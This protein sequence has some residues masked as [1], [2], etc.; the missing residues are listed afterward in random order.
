MNTK[1]TTLIVISVIVILASTLIAA[2][3]SGSI[4][5]RSVSEPK[6][7]LHNPVLGGSNSLMTNGPSTRANTGSSQSPVPDYVVYGQLFRAVVLIKQ[8]TEK[9]E[10]TGRNVTGSAIQGLFNLSETEATQLEES[11]LAWQQEAESII[12][13]ADAIIT[14]YR[15]DRSIAAAE[16]KE[17]PA[18]PEEL[19]QLQESLNS[20]ILNARDKLRD[21]LGDEAFERFEKSVEGNITANIKTKSLDLKNLE[22]QITDGTRPPLRRS[23]IDALRGI[24][25][26]Q[27][28]EQASNQSTQS[29]QDTQ[30]PGAQ[31]QDPAFNFC[32]FGGVVFYGTFLW[33]A[34]Q[35]DTVFQLSLTQL[36]ICAGLIYD[37]YVYGE[38]YVGSSFELWDVAENLGRS[39]FRPAVIINQAFAFPSTLYTAY[40]QHWI[41]QCGALSPES[42]APACFWTFVIDYV[43]QGVTPQCVNGG[44]PLSANPNFATCP[45]PSPSPTPTPTVT[46]DSV[47]FTG[48]FMIRHWHKEPAMRRRFDDP[49]GSEPAWSR[50]S[51]DKKFPAA[52]KKGTNPTMFA[53]F[54][55]NPATNTSRAVQIR[56]KKGATV[57]ATKSDNIGGGQ[58]TVR[59]IT[60]NFGG[61]ETAELVKRGEYEFTWEV[62]FDNGAN[63]GPAGKS[64]KHTIFWTW[65]AP[66]DETFKNRFNQKCFDVPNGPQECNTLYDEALRHSAGETGEDG[67]STLNDVIDKINKAAA[68]DTSYDPSKPDPPEHPLAILDGPINRVG[69]CSG[70]ANFL[71]G[72]LR[73]IGINATTKYWW[74]GDNVTKVAEIYSYNTAANKVSFRVER[75]AI[76]E[77]VPVER[78]PH[79]KFHATVFIGEPTAP[80]N[81]ANAY[82]PSYKKSGTAADV[83]LLEASKYPN[84]G[85]FNGKTESNPRRVES[86]DMLTDQNQHDTLTMCNHQPQPGILFPNPI[87]EAEFFVEQHYMDILNRASDPTGFATW[88]PMITQ[89]NGEP[90]CVF[91]RRVDVTMGFIP[92]GEYLERGYFIQR[93]YKASYARFPLF[94]EEFLPGY[95][96]I[97]HLVASSE[98]LEHNKQIFADDWVASEAFQT[99]YPFNMEHSTYVDLLFSNA[100]ITPD[101]GERDTLINGLVNGTE[102]RATV[103]R[104]VV[105]NPTFYNSYFNN[106]FVLSCY[107]TYLRRDPDTNGYN[108][109]ITALPTHGYRH[110][111]TG[112]IYSIEY[113]ARFGQP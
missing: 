11:A 8:Q 113:R 71:R 48:D 2:R 6:L 93:F 61:L 76:N 22:G 73:S 106:A 100:G 60:V 5:I 77:G 30:A 101:P 99:A 45:G 92:G 44:A 90:N 51:S 88:V 108:D 31:G 89:C 80:F 69:Q 64:G 72:L 66:L 50:S 24:D 54:R 4:G 39:F 25:S 58:A 110:V 98:D 49:D 62:S 68:K 47:G 109:W 74:G 14:K 9:D 28:N 59:D 36:D 13:Q 107:F 40:A 42:P 87:D 1:R 111:V 35:I 78:D 18:V 15:N 46:I 23:G 37:P 38:L 41:A 29:E 32:F 91:Q 94:R 12:G 7:A 57:V 96:T 3:P 21:R 17:L 33:L 103:L 104:K 65:D 55:L 27:T 105:D 52:Y 53:T 79:F 63:W 95:G 20:S 34:P 70:I 56:V 67:A 84:P 83:Q 16:G 43:V 97:A 86:N 75:D 10:Q 82:D 112:F 85:F 26:P 19:G 102:N 81:P